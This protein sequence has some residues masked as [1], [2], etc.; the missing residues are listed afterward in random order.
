VSAIVKTALVE[1]GIEKQDPF[2]SLKI[3]GEGKDKEEG[4]TATPEQLKEIARASLDTM[5]SRPSLL[6][7]LQMELGTRIGEVA[8]LGIDD[9]FLDHETPHVYFRD[10]PWRTLKNKESERRVP[11]VGIALEALKK[12][13]ALP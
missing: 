13:V 10:K 5:S 8:G 11:V 3:Q 9:V 7:L 1:L 6:I 4:K 12:A 2:R